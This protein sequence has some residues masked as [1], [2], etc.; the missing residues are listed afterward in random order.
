M[1]TAHI[2]LVNQSEEIGEKQL[3]DF[4][5]KGG[6]ISPLMYIPLYVYNYFESLKQ[7]H[8]NHYKIIPPHVFIIIYLIPEKFVFVPVIRIT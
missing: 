2:L 8:L 1:I 5:S 7:Y 4:G 3:S 6:L